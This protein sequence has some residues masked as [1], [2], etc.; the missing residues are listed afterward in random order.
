MLCHPPGL[1]MEPGPHGDE[2]PSPAH[3]PG[4]G[5]QH[6]LHGWLSRWDPSSGPQPQGRE[7]SASLTPF[8]SVQGSWSWICQT[9]PSRP[10]T[11]G[12]AL[13]ECW[14]LTP[15]GPTSSSTSTRPSLRW[16]M[17]LAGGL[18]RSSM[19]A[20]GACRYELGRMP[21]A[22]VTGLTAEPHCLVAK[23]CPTLFRPHGL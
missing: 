23:L 17:W 19:V 3:H 13:S 4:L 22:W 14:R 7:V 21:V 1:H 12:C 5:Q 9:C 16:R 2:V 20:N 8:L 11:P 18:A 10:R 6:H 15:S